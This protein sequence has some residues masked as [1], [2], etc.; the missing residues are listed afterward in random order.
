M[1]KTNNAMGQALLLL[2]TYVWTFMTCYV[3]MGLI[4]SHYNIIQILDNI[5]IHLSWLVI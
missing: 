1:T 2:D 4:E 3:L 5:L